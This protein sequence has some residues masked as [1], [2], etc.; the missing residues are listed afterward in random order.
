MKEEPSYYSILTA[1]IRY[2][3]NLSANEKLLYSEITAL[4]AKTGVCWSTNNYFAKLY[5]VSKETVSRW[6][7]HLNDLH[8]IC[9]QVVRDVETREVIERS[10][11][12]PQVEYLKSIPIDEKINTPPLKKINTP[13]LKNVKENNINNNNINIEHIKKFS[14][15]TKEEVVEYARTR[16]RIDLADQFYDYFETGNWID[17]KGNKVRNWKQKFITWEKYQVSANR[18]NFEARNYTTEEMNDLFDNL[19]D[20]EV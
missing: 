4:M 17:S 5:G 15:P 9:V 1:D 8:Y 11:T 6:I 20:V 7:K 14:P 3:N 10:I 12:L 16:N 13:P 19:D 2:D 18:N